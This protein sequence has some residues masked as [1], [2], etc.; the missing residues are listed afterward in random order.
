MY[1]KD[2]FSTVAAVS[3]PRGKGGIAVIRISGADTAKILEK[4]FVPRGRPMSERPYRTAVYGD[5]VSDGGI[6]D[7]GVCVLYEE[8]RSFTGESMAELS[9]HGGIY[10]TN[11]VLET[12]F[13]AGAEP[14]GPGEFTK[15]AFINGKLSLSEAEAVG[16][17]IDA[18]TKSRAAMASGAARG[19]LTGAIKDI[20][21]GMVDVMTALYAAIDYPDEDVGTEGEDRIYRVVSDSLLK[22]EALR[23]T[24]K[25]G[26]AVAEGIKTVIC[27]R[28]NVGKSSLYNMLLGEDR[29]IVTDVPGTTRD[30]LEDTVDVGGARYCGDKGDRR[31][32][33]EDRSRACVFQARRGGARHLRFRRVRAND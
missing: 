2:P 32:S 16:Q 24:Y 15:R 5:V 19:N 29:A 7:T 33:R 11:E 26:R 9:C 17:L 10:V 8:G 21:R 31:Q 28:P 25:T 23:K 6:I 18:D 13:A 14:A 12:V 20:D 4:C 27:G 30:T 3:T 1:V 22:V